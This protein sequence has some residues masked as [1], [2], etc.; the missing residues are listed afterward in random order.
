MCDG[1]GEVEIMFEKGGRMWVGFVKE[2]YR[3][4]RI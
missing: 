2:D 1:G 4:G 3:E